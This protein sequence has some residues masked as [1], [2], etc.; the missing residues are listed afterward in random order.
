MGGVRPAIMAMQ[1]AVCCG[2]ILSTEKVNGNTL[3]FNI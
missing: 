1:S 2:F 3:K